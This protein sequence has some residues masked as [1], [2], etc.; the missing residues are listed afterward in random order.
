MIVNSNHSILL[1]LRISRISFNNL[2]WKKLINIK[3]VFG[4]VFIFALNFIYLFFQLV[5]IVFCFSFLNILQI[6]W[7][8]W[9]E[10][11]ILLSLN[12]FNILFILLNLFFHRLYYEHLTFLVYN[13]IRTRALSRIIEFLLEIDFSCFSLILWFVVLLRHYLRFFYLNA[14]L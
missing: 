7:Y 12:C 2:N 11:I 8:F 1:N 9:F 6:I 10:F 5:N 13:V 14:L 4:I 3:C